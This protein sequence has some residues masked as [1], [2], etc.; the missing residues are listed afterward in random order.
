MRK[1]KISIAIII[2][3]GLISL[4]IDYIYYQIQSYKP[5]TYDKI[6]VINLARSK[7]WPETKARMDKEGIEYSRFEAID[8]ND[9]LVTDLERDKTMLGKYMQ[10]N[11]LLM[12]KNKKYQINCNPQSTDPTKFIV[13]STEAD[14]YPGEA[15]LWCSNLLIWKDA[16]KHNYQN[17]VVFEDDIIPVG[18]HFNIWLNNYVHALPKTYDVAYL[19]LRWLNGSPLPIK[20]NNY[21]TKFD[22]NN[23]FTG[24]FAMVYSN[25]GINKLLNVLEI[26]HH[27]DSFLN[28]R[29]NYAKPCG[30]LIKTDISLESYGSYN[31]RIKHPP[32]SNSEMQRYEQPKD[33]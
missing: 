8:G 6:Y 33:D 3:L 7:R 32:I 14:F 10:D 31:D 1:V 26:D 9:I 13:H 5:L 24:T 28:S 21:V 16:L 20:K 18:R 2:L 27:I 17:I 19:S 29:I 12:N 4:V 22:N 11:K 30:A 15:G 23:C 25:R